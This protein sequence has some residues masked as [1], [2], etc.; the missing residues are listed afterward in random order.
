MGRLPAALS[1]LGPGSAL[2]SRPRVALSSAQALSAYITGLWLVHVPL[3]GLGSLPRGGRRQLL[4]PRGPDC[5]GATGELIRRSDVRDGAVQPDRVVQQRGRRPTVP[6]PVRCITVGIRGSVGRWR[7][8]Q[9]SSGVIVLCL[10]AGSRRTSRGG[11]LNCRGGCSIG[12][13][14]LRCTPRSRPLWDA[15]SCDG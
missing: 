12:L 11:H 4:P 2:R 7:S 15:T 13:S 9:R 14:V 8:S 3:L 1:G 5:L 10:G 6:S